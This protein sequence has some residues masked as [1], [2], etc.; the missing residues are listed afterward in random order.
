MV[1][2]YGY[3]TA[4]VSNKAIQECG[5][6]TV[7]T[8]LSI[9]QRISKMPIVF[10]VINVEGGIYKSSESIEGKTNLQYLQSAKSI[11]VVYECDHPSNSVIVYPQGGLEE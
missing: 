6:T 10:Y 7:G 8:V 2:A 3:Y 9:K 11:E 1:L 5:V 4:R